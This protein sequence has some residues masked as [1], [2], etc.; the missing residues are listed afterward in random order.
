M[1]RKLEQDNKDLKNQLATVQ[2]NLTYAERL[3][4]EADQQCAE[5]RVECTNAQQIARHYEVQFSQNLKPQFEALQRENAQLREQLGES[6]CECRGGSGG[7]YSHW[8]SK[9]CWRQ[10]SLPC[11]HLASPPPLRYQSR[12]GFWGALSLSRTLS[13]K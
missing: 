10:G 5:A 9:Q 13:P 8:L 1:C 2:A 3:K 4:K 6:L 12:A 7:L 11:V